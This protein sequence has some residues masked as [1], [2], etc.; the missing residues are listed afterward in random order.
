MNFDSLYTLEHHKIRIKWKWCLL[1]LLGC[2]IGTCLLGSGL[3][4]GVTTPS[5]AGR[6]SASFVAHSLFYSIVPYVLYKCSFKKP[7]TRFLSI[8][9]FLIPAHAFLIGFFF[10][11]SFSFRNA[12]ISI[13]FFT[14]TI[15]WIVYSL[16]LRKLNKKIQKELFTQGI[17]I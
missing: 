12:L 14:T 7:G 16:K 6:M 3:I 13:C 8:F 2:Y 4:S 10:L 5:E 15:S 11:Y 1:S 9:L 17:Y